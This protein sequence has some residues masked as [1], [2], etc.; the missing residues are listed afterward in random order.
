MEIKKFCFKRSQ[1][2]FIPLRLL[3]PIGEN[4]EIDEFI[5]TKMHK[6][7]RWKI[8]SEREQVS[9]EVWNDKISIN[10][11]GMKKLAFVDYTPEM[12]YLIR[13]HVL[14]FLI[15][16]KL[17]KNTNIRIQ[18]NIRNHYIRSHLIIISGKNCG[19]KHIVRII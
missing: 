9:L 14:E 6:N 19:K 12:Y 15:Q 10:I 17:K 1:K 13:M 5:Y 11:I 18:M 3:V 16:K 8:M 4:N 2:C 7:R